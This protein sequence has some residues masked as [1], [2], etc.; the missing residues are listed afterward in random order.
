LDNS[1]EL[2]KLIQGKAT[3]E[4]L[5]ALTTMLQRLM[6]NVKSEE[7]YL[8]PLNGIPL[9]DLD[10]Q[11][12]TEIAKIEQSYR[13]GK[14]I[15]VT[16]LPSNVATKDD[17]IT[18]T[19]G[20][21]NNEQ[22]ARGIID[23]VVEAREG[24]LGITL[25]GN[26][27][28]RALK[29]EIIKTINNT[30]EEI[31]I[32]KE[33]LEVLDHNEM[34]ELSRGAPE[35]H[36]AESISYGII[37]GEGGAP[38]IKNNVKAILDALDTTVTGLG[39]SKANKDNLIQ[40]INAQTLGDPP[41]KIEGSRV[42]FSSAEHNDFGGRSEVG[43]H[44]STAITHGEGT[45]YSELSGLSTAITDI[46]NS[47]KAGGYDPLTNYGSIDDRLRCLEQ[48]VGAIAGAMVPPIA[49]PVCLQRP[50]GWYD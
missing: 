42:N 43:C 34:S 17:V 27:Q 25:K 12:K 1:E 14:P 33:H 41:A 24:A 4:E 39:I 45:V 30:S 19:R 22:R 36:P 16:D 38:D 3:R 23:E 50:P 20:I 35:A 29:S 7:F 10:G 15:D 32:G 9:Q 2:Y 26:I 47:L 48:F 11:L 49:L 31:V 5:R 21:T 8:K 37:P 44:P 6:N 40:E 28:R 46:G 13:S 18:A